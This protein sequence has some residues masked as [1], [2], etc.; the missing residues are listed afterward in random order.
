MF[1][2]HVAWLGFLEE[3]GRGSAVRFEILEDG[4]SLGYFVG[5]ELRKGPFRVL[6]S[7]LSSSMTEY[8]GPIVNNCIAVQ[9]FLEALDGLCRQRGIH[10]LEIGSPLLA[11][12]EVCELGYEAEKWMTFR[13]ALDPD[14]ES[15]WASLSSKGRN[16]IRR[17]RKNGLVA[18]DSGDPA[19]VDRHFRQVREVFN[20]QKLSPP[21]SVEDFRA[22]VRWLKPQELVF[23]LEVRREATGEVLASGIFPHDRR[24]VYSL[25]TASWIHA[26]SEYPNEILHW[27][28]MRLAAKRGISQYN[29]GDNYRTPES[30]G[31]FKNKF[32]GSYEPVYRFTRSYSAFA[33]YA[34]KLFVSVHRL[35]RRSGLGYGFLQARRNEPNVGSWFPPSGLPLQ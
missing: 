28:V 26:R 2:H 31:Q 19:F 5:M 29:L 14:E 7:P 20:R 9:P 13:I 27:S 11:P 30:G 23:T 18:V 4:I 25:S 21:F 33:K 24:R 15:L 34:R 32:G 35:K 3:T 16:R 1:Y 22:L 8:M 12:E 6:G 17:A 10:H